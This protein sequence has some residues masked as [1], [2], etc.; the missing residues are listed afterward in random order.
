MTT[1]QVKGIAIQYGDK[2]YEYKQEVLEALKL[3][4]G[5]H[6]IVH[7]G[8]EVPVTV[9]GN[10]VTIHLD[11]TRGNLA[12]GT[13]IGM[14]E[15]WTMA[16]KGKLKRVTVEPDEGLN[17]VSLQIFRNIEGIVLLLERH[18]QQPEVF[19]FFGRRK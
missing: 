17:N 4:N 12:E 11:K 19:D 15:E 10:A 9:N 8:L 13:I 3:S 7:N 5:D 2:T 6:T 18:E 1:F 16:Q 14:G